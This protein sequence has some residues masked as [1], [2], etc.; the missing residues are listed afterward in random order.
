M[1]KYGTKN[2][3]LLEGLRNEEAQLMNQMAASLADPSKT[4]SERSDIDR[5]L[6]QVR[7]K[8]YELDDVNLGNDT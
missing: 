6:Q 1:E 3:D 2:L 7:M 4:A 8:I 5:R